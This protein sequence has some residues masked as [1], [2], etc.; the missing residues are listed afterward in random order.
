MDTVPAIMQLV[1]HE[2]ALTSVSSRSQVAQLVTR[3]GVVELEV[4]VREDTITIDGITARPVVVYEIT[5]LDHET[6]DD[7]VECGSLVPQ[8]FPMRTHSF[9]SCVTWKLGVLKWQK[10]QRER[11]SSI[12]GGSLMPINIMQGSLSCNKF[13]Q[14][15]LVMKYFVINIKCFVDTLPFPF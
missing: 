13:R 5:A 1:R 3:F 6:W 11:V 15:K 9:L 7:P 10:N 4:L 8:R 12:T 14:N 2:L